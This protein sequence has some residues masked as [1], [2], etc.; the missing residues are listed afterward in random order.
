MKDQTVQQAATGAAI[1]SLPGFITKRVFSEQMAWSLRKT[2]MLLQQRKIPFIKLGKLV[3]IPWPEARD[4][5]LRNYK[6]N[7]IGE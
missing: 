7:P 6:I 4:H 3:R 1:E 5:L 2:D